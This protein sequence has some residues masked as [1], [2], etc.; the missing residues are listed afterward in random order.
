MLLESDRMPEH[1]DKRR[2]VPEGQEHI[3][4]QSKR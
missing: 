1:T 4:G 2:R 3:S